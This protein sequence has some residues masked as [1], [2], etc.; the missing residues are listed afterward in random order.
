VRVPSESFGSATGANVLL[1][2]PTIP[3][4]SDADLLEHISL[5]EELRV[6]HTAAAR[7]GDDFDATKF[8]LLIDAQPPCA[9][10]VLDRVAAI[11]GTAR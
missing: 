2:M 7:R 11:C 4:I 9:D 3:G 5:I 6:A 1:V 10:A 8:R